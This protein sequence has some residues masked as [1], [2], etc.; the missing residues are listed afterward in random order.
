MPGNGNIFFIYSWTLIEIFTLCLCVCV[1]VSGACTVHS[2]CMLAKEV[3]G[4][5]LILSLSFCCA[6]RSAARS[7]PGALLSAT[8]LSEELDSA[9]DSRQ[10]ELRVR[11]RSGVNTENCS[12]RERHWR[13]GGNLLQM[14]VLGSLQELHRLTLPWWRFTRGQHLFQLAPVSGV[15]RA[16]GHA[17]FH[18]CVRAWRSKRTR[19]MCNP[20]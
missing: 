17:H 18:K 4:A 19:S 11:D 2:T 3:W 7:L 16:P 8:G 6:A 9:S 14:G 15:R 20:S 10:S 12:D 5:S 1:C 13:P